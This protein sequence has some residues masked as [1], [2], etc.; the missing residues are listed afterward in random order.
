MGEICINNQM[1]HNI[2]ELTYEGSDFNDRSVKVDRK[3]ERFIGVCYCHSQIGERQN[4]QEN[5]YY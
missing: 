3:N 5:C 1:N 2:F 4:D